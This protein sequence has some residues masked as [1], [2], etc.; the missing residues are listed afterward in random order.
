MN[1]YNYMAPD[2][3][4]HKFDDSCAV[5]CIWSMSTRSNPTRKIS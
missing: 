2:E 4:R 5:R 1:D 3:Q